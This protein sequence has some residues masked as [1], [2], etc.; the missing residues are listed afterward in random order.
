MPVPWGEW[1]TVYTRTQGDTLV[2]FAERF[3]DGH[4]VGLYEWIDD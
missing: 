2:V 4:R 3:E 1:R